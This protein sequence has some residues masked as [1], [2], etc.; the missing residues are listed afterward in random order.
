MIV[1]NRN[2]LLRLINLPICIYLIGKLI[3]NID[4]IIIKKKQNRAQTISPDQF[5]TTAVLSLMKGADTKSAAPGT[6]NPLKKPGIL[7]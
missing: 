7:F 4:A 1:K 2:F 6:G 3:I 5:T